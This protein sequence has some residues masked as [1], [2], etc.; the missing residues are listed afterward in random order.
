MYVFL[1]FVMFLLYICKNRAKLTRFR[2]KNRKKS[3]VYQI[4]KRNT[5][6]APSLGVTPAI[7]EPR[8]QRPFFFTTPTKV[9]NTMQWASLFAAAAYQTPSSRLRLCTGLYS[10]L[11][12]RPHSR[13]VHK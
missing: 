10:T 8:G 11:K 4:Y 13:Y 5:R 3:Y 12:I 7:K 1:G 9:P 2:E 6:S